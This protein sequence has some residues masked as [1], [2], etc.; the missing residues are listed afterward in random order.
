MVLE[1]DDI[2]TKFKIGD[3]VEGEITGI[4]NYGVFVSLSDRKSVV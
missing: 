4:Q 1:G 3:I 2:V